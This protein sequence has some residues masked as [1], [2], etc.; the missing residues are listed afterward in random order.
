M[1]RYLIEELCAVGPDDAEWQSTQDEFDFLD[2]AT[3]RASA[4][5]QATE[6][7]PSGVRVWDAYTE[8]VVWQS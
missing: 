3:E 8:A 4:M 2:A 6:H 5:V 1:K 7:G